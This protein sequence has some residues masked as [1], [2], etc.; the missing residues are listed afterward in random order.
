MNPLTRFK[1]TRILA[2]LSALTFAVAVP[3]GATPQCGVTS[4]NLL[5]PGTT[6]GGFFPSGLLDLMCKQLPPLPLWILLTQ[7]NGDSDLY[8]TQLTFQ[9]GGQT[10]WHTHPGPSLVTVTE[11]TVTAYEHDCT[12]ATYSAGQSFTDIACGDVHNVRNE[13]SAEAKTVAVQLV[14]HGAPRRINA[15]DPGCP[16]VPPCPASTP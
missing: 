5:F 16:Q 11:G 10:G 15:D 14:P 8:I 13:T 6:M 4:T 2:L 9:P 1:K 3:A 7:V 12:F